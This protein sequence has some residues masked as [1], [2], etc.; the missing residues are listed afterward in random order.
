MRFENFHQNII[1]INSF[2]ER[3]F[4]ASYFSSINFKIIMDNE[5]V[6][7]KFYESFAQHDVEGMIGCYHNNVVFFD[8]AF[9]E[10]TGADAKNM[11]RMLLSRGSNIKIT[12]SNVHAEGNSGS[13][14]WQAEYVYSQTGRN[15]IN[16]I[17]ARFEFDDG[18]II[19]HTDNFDLWKWT[20]QA[21]GF[22]GYLLGW[23]PFMKMKIRKQ[24]NHLL[25]IFSR[26]MR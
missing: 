16:K 14:D 19:K 24:T 9:G 5:T 7:K 26:R 11:W 4:Q 17:S 13:A 1:C 12:F 8:P 22:K 25:K 3:T 10:L 21:L 2:T 18:K 23:S 15:V 20:R 6:I